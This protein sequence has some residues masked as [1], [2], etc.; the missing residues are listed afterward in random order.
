MEIYDKRIRLYKKQ[1]G[2]NGVILKGGSHLGCCPNCTSG[3][4]NWCSISVRAYCNECGWWSRINYGSTKEG[5]TNLIRLQ[6][7]S[8]VEATN[9]LRGNTQ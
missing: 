4:M 5:L 6:E 1:I 8:G 7:R 3:D 9:M 2:A